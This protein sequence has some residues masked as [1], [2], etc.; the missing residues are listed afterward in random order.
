MKLLSS[1]VRGSSRAEGGDL[2]EISK[3]GPFGFGL[4]KF[5]VRILIGGFVDL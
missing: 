2:V 1:S 3:R 4:V 5:Y